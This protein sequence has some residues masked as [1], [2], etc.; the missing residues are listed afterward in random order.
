MSAL[1]PKYTG[2]SNADC[3]STMKSLLAISLCVVCLVPTAQGQLFSDNFSRTTLPPWIVYSGT[4]GTWA[5]TNGAMRGGP[6][7]SGYGFAYIT[8][9]F[10]NFSVQ[11]QFRFTTNA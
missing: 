11:G 5:V 7:S 6:N 9:N 1:P 2:R 3:S 4:P 10:T 8:N